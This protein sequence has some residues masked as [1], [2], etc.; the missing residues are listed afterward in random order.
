MQSFILN[1]LKSIPTM[2]RAEGSLEKVPKET[3]Y[4][5]GLDFSPV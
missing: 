3:I 4:F 5:V 2:P 1:R